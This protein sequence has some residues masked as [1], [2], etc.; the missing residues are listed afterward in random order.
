MLTINDSRVVRTIKLKNKRCLH[1]TEFAEVYLDCAPLR[2]E[3]RCSH[4][5]DL[6]LDLLGAKSEK[7]REWASV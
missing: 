1:I 6:P 4:L 7:I 3:G 2:G 5:G